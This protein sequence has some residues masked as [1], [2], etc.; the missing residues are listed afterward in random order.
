MAEE[1]H[2]WVMRKPDE[3]MEPADPAA[4]KPRADEV[5]VEIDACSL[6]RRNVGFAFG[7]VH[8][9]S[10]RA[11]EILHRISG[12]V[13]EA[14]E[15]ALF[16]ADRPVVMSGVVPCGEHQACWTGGAVE[17]PH[18][19]PPGADR[20]AMGARCVVAPAREVTAAEKHSPHPVGPG[21]EPFKDG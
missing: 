16:Y 5:L 1:P 3:P 21:L 13:I 12:H 6:W 10:E 15:D 19:A 17:C 2:R 14:G 18:K 9:G 4:R 7:G 11:P 8:G 20:E